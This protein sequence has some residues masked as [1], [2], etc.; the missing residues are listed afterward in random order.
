MRAVDDDRSLGELFGDLGRQVGTLVRQEVDLAKTELSE[1]ASRTGR[2]VATLAV[3]GAVAYAGLLV[4]LLAA[5]YAL[6]AA[7]LE[8]WL[9][10][11]LVG[12][13]VVA[14]GGFLVWRGLQQFRETDLT[15]RRT[16]ETMKENVE[17][18]KEHPK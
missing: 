6:I 1:K 8:S 5:V 16:V 7:G 4:L 18:I 13:V 9:A 14:I 3:G 12:A 15:P 11:L 10:A 17:M 2:N